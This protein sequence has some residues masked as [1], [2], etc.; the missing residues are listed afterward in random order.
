DR[1]G[2]LRCVRDALAVSR[3]VNGAQKTIV[4]HQLCALSRALVELDRGAEAVPLVHEAI[5]LLPLVDLPQE[6]ATQ[7]ILRNLERAAREHGCADLLE[8][9]RPHI[10]AVAA[11]TRP[12]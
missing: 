4:L 2:A 7:R 9:V 3:R 12:T 10:H 11:S 8:L 1:E 5:T 6:R